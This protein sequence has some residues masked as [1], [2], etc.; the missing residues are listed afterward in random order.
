MLQ[1]LLSVKL[2]EISKNPVYLLMGKPQ[3]IVVVDAIDPLKMAHALMSNTY[4]VF[5][6]LHMMWMCIWMSPYH[7]K[8]APVCLAFGNFIES[9]LPPEANH[10][11]L[12]LLRL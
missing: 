5:D 7:F 9:W 8:A 2:L 6:N 10:S 3:R 1:L 11:I 12:W 4:N